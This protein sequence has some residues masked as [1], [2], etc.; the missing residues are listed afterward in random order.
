MKP[1]LWIA[2]ALAAVAPIA[3]RPIASAAAEVPVTTAVYQPSDAPLDA[4]PVH[5]RPYRGYYGYRPYYGYYRPYYAWRPDG[6]YRP[7]VYR[8]Y[9]YGPYPYA[10]GYAPPYY[11]GYRY[12]RYGVYYSGPGFSFG[13]RW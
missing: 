13:Y 6:Y 1:S 7:Y 4:T 2:L 8:P 9:V 12:P 3:C 5:Y 11:Y 10:Y